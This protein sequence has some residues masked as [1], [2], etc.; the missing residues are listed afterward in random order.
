VDSEVAAEAVWL[1]RYGRNLD[2]L[3]ARLSQPATSIDTRCA[4]IS[5]TGWFLD[6]AASRRERSS[7]NDS[8]GDTIT[9]SVAAALADTK[10]ADVEALRMYCR[11]VAEDQGA[12][13]VE[14]SVVLGQLGPMIQIIYKQ[15]DRPAFTFTGMQ[16]ITLPK[17]SLIWSVVAREKG[18]TGVREAVVTKS[19]FDQGLLTLELYEHS[20]ACDPYDPHYRA[21]DRSV[22]RYM[23][24]DASYDTQ[25]PGHPLSKVRA[26]LRELSRESDLAEVVPNLPMQSTGFTGE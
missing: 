20:W 2:S 23:S 4:A 9:L 14:A 24:D 17:T 10:T 3:I 18:T 11:Q 5:S 8:D 6:K 26:V 25:F 1:L 7:W 12:G 21:V 15:L 13:L 19:L 16:I 22:L